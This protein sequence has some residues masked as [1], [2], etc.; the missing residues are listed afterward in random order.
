LEL[1]I[2]TPH[3]LYPGGGERYILSIAAALQ[4]RFR[5][6]LITP[7]R[8]SL[9]HVRTVLRE[10]DIFL[11]HVAPIALSDVRRAAPFDL[12]VAMGNHVL[13]E[14]PALGGRSIFHCQFPF[15]CSAEDTGRFWSNL[16]GYD[17]AIVNSHFTAHHLRQAADRSGLVLP[18]VNVLHPPVPQL[19][20]ARDGAGSDQPKTI[21]LNVG[22]FAPCGHAKGQHVLIAEFRRL[23]RASG[24]T[25]E[26]HLAGAVDESET[27]REYFWQITQSA[28]D[29]PVFFHPNLMAADL[30]DLYKRATIYWHATGS[31]EDVRVRPERFE[32]FGIALVEAMSAGAVAVAIRFG[33]PAEI[34]QDG[35][36]GVLISDGSEFS[37]CTQR[38]LEGADI[39]RLARSA[40][41]RA[42]AFS[43]EHFAERLSEIVSSIEARSYSAMR[44]SKAEHSPR[45]P[46][47]GVQ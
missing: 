22:R 9:S 14:V 46:L 44:P 38:L 28:H 3:P 23:L 45:S 35:V 8:Y 36:N 10:L 43:F 39:E 25:L 20:E 13:P 33:G 11:D 41:E 40:R 5:C 47:A 27:G 34:I 1:A 42:A 15:P 17:C 24:L 26:L 4:D 21:I 6:T 37:A 16:N 19:G 32:H 30:K 18:P 29:I 31:G 12:F 7:D 2:F